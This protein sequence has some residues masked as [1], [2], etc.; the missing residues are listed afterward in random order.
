MEHSLTV[1]D[2]VDKLRAKMDKVRRRSRRRRR[3]RRSSGGS[4]GGPSGGAWIG[5]IK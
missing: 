4:G 2:E 1:Q 5:M 3:R